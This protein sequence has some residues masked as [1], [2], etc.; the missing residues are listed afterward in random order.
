MYRKCATS[1]KLQMLWTLLRTLES[2]TEWNSHA[3]SLFIREFYTHVAYTQ[4]TPQVSRCLILCVCVW[5]IRTFLADDCEFQNSII[6]AWFVKSN[7]NR[8][9]FIIK[10]NVE[11]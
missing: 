11:K 7:K 10:R 6:M 2:E 5:F 3:N 4:K 1:T 9:E 8:N